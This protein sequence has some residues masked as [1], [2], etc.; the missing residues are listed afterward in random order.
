MKIYIKYMVSLRCKLAV[1]AELEKLSISF[2]I[3]ELGEVVI[4][5]SLTEKQHIDLKR[6]LMRSGLELMD[7]TKAQVI[8]KIKPI[9]I[10][11]VHYKEEPLKTNFSVF[12]SE[13]LNYE[14]TY[15]SQLFSQATG[16]TIEQYIISQKI[17]RAKELLLYNELNL[18]E[19]SYLLNYSS[20]AHLSSQFKKVT[21]LTPT[22]FKNLKQHKRRIMLED[23]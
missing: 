23:I 12:L 5:D 20:V 21:G 16:T 6:G 2:G 17:E 22:F 11:M 14:Y 15:L 18:T 9:I 4:N 19:I 8:E 13:Q 10:E 1:K 7:D 3:I